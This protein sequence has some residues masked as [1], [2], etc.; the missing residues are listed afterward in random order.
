M[1]DNS[2]RLSL[3]YLMPSQAQKHVTH[4][5]ALEVL[6]VLVQLRLNGLDAITPPDLAEDGTVYA[7]GTG[8]SGAWAGQDGMLAARDDGAWRFVA[9]QEGWQ[10]VLLP[11]ALPHVRTATG[12]KPLQGATQNLDGVGIGTGSDTTN[13]LAVAADASLFSHAGAGHQVKLNKAT[14]GDTASLLYKSGWSGRA[15]IGLAGNDDLS[16]KVSADGSAWVTALAIDGASGALRLPPGAAPADPQA[17]QLYFDAATSRL[18]CHD[19][20]LWHDLF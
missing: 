13:R 12:W 17:G 18:R 19:G 16:V 15:E 10:V 20:S 6:D 1:P 5:S 8:A 14:A 2:S 4:N 3:P 7:L 11:D 9:A